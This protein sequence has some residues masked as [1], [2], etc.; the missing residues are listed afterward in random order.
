MSDAR[1]FTRTRDM[2][3]VPSVRT[4]A[5]IA[6]TALLS[7]A[8]SLT[9]ASSANA[10]RTAPKGKNGKVATTG[11]TMVPASF[12]VKLTPIAQANQPLA[13]VTRPNDEVL[14]IVEKQGMIRAWEKGSFRNKA[15]LDITQSVDTDNER[16]LLGLAFHPTKRD[17]LF[18]DYTNKKGDVVVSELT[19]DGTVADYAK[20]RVLLQIPK[21]FN[22]HNA[23]TIFFDR[24]GLLYIAIGDGGG[25]NDKF[26]NAQ[27]T[28]SLLG[29]ILR[30]DPTPTDAKPYSIPKANPFAAT[31][32]GA[33]KKRGEIYAYGLRNP[34]RASLDAVSGDMWIPDV[35]Q[36]AVEEINRMPKGKSGFN[37]GW[38]LREGRSA[39]SGPKPR[40]ATDPVYDY[41]H[42]D[43]RC[44]VV[45]GEVYRGAAISALRGW[46]VFSDVCS[47]RMMALQPVGTSSQNTW[48]PVDL[49]TRA[50]YVT[51]FGVDQS[52][53]LYVTSLEG[54]V[55]RIDPA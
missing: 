29:K 51:S 4:L 24:D 7:T 28:D 21:P 11:T 8:L 34:W 36:A 12:A 35:G 9:I 44:A 43:N 55:F 46:Y 38:K 14:Y 26:N 10:E 1:P 20:E 31:G 23:G 48:Q 18:I 47:G 33:T 49:G 3:I 30:I 6:S 15:V 42:A 40:G 52:G 22:E 5:V 53:E 32:L 41:P 54:G 37:F 13:V 17:S 25:A 39:G 45:G 50:P 2:F 19:F 27:R 16:G